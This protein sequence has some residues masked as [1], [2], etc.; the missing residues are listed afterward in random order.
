M[1]LAEIRA[2]ELTDEG[3]GKMFLDNPYLPARLAAEQVVI[4]LDTYYM[5]SMTPNLEGL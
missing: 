4:D 2:R 5:E 3:F 1:G